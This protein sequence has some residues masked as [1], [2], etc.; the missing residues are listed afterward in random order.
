MASQHDCPIHACLIGIY[1]FAVVP[2]HLSQALRTP[3]T[4]DGEAHVRMQD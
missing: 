4:I 2:V 1:A 3:K